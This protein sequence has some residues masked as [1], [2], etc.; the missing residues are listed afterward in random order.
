VLVNSQFVTER[1]RMIP[2]FVPDVEIVLSQM[3]VLDVVKGMEE[4]IVKLQSVLENSAMIQRRVQVVAR[5]DCRIIVAIVRRD[6]L[7]LIA[8]FPFVMDCRPIQ[9]LFVV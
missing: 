2:V 4:A 1:F 7:D 9:P 6:I 5:V 3:Y 8:N